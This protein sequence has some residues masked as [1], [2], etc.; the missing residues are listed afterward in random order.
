MD[1]QAVAVNPDFAL[2][3]SLAARSA[4]TLVPAKLPQGRREG[5][6]YLAINPR[7][8]DAS[9]GS[10]KVN[11]ETGSWSD[12][13]TGDKGG[14]LISLWAF[15]DGSN[16]HEAKEALA[17]ALGLDGGKGNPGGGGKGGGGNGLTLEAYAAAKRLP[18]E[19]LKRLGVATAPDPWGKPRSVLSIP[20]K[21]R[22][23][24]LHRSRLRVSL[25]KGA[26]GAP[27]L[28]WDKR[29][30]KIGALLYGLDTLP[31]RSSATSAKGC[32]VILVEG[33]S[34][35]HTLWF[36][37]FDAV[38]CPGAANYSPARDDTELE[39]FEL[40]AFVEPDKGGEALVKQLAKSKHA[41]RI[42]LARLPMEF[43]DASAVHLKAPERFAEIVEAAI[44]GTVPLPSKAL[45]APAADV[46]A[47]GDYVDDGHKPTVADQL[48]K[49]AR[50][51]A[52][53]FTAPDGVAYAAVE[54]EKHREIWPLRSKAFR[55]WVIHRFFARAGRAPSPDTIAQA[56]M[57]LEAVALFQGEKRPVATRTAAHDG[58]LYIDLGDE[59]WRA[60]EIGV[61]GWRIVERPPVMFKRSNGALP[62]PEPVR[63]GRIEELKGLL[64]VAS[65][66]DF[67]LVVAWLVAALRPRGPYP[68]LA[69]AGEPGT[70]KTSTATLLR[71]LVDPHVA[72]IRRP[73]REERDMFISASKT[74]ALV[75]DNLSSIPEWLSDGL[76]VVATGGTFAARAM[77]T[78]DEEALFTVERPV[79]I[80]SVG[81]VISR[82]DLADRA[83]LVTLSTI[84]DSE[85][86]SKEA[87]EA[88]LEA[89]RPRILGALF[90]AL[91]IGLRELPNVRLG[92]LPRMA[93]FVLFV[94]ACEGAFDWPEG[95]VY[96]A[97][98]RNVSDAVEG[99]LEGD[100]VAVALRA[101]FA[102]RSQ[103]AWT[104]QTGALLGELNHWAEIEAKRDRAW[105][106]NPQ[107]FTS[108]LT[109]AAP[110]LR[111]I[112][113]VVERGP[114]TKASRQLSVYLL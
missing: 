10:F 90:D 77:R 7:R 15:V 45:K 40:V 110:A 18:V 25:D 73:P 5:V 64:N 60:V 112:G 44:A 19:F 4:A 52:T 78:D 88:Q 8:A 54:V 92:N 86:M 82:S 35:A 41:G 74:A 29:S 79:M 89:A 24:S 11:L 49:L 80:T 53:F 87:W 36:H 16:Q 13:A 28:V 66:D 94:T 48:V 69:L 75:Y 81:E 83:M 113:I 22:D 14:D 71:S 72:G 62:L 102:A 27:R 58:K 106:R 93:D 47:A 3:R 85:R 109:M 31:K 100:A 104:G 101:W 97:F 111:K 9:L 34:D 39:G 51:A 55:S 98:K 12:F 50:Q 32:R 63:G 59:A 76:C 91:S 17:G 105:P 46:E 42:K 20:Y 6:E 114:R 57:T 43:K 61:D 33:E 21:K 26:D 30:E 56:Q 99:V 65:E 108:R 37:G 23:G 107:A 38:A 95:A 1:S 70:S 68:L 2:V 84:P 67:K 103:E 96:A